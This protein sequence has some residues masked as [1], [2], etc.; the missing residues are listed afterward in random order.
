MPAEHAVMQIAGKINELHSNLSRQNWGSASRS[1]FLASL[2]KSVDALDDLY[3]LFSE[4]IAEIEKEH[5]VGKPDLQPFLGEMQKLLE[6]LHRNLQM[7]KEKKSVAKTVNV[8]EKEETPELYSDLQQKILAMLL[9]SRYSL[10]RISV[11]LR[12]QG[13]EIVTD[14]S[15]AKQVIEVLQRKEDELQDLRGKY[16][17]IRKKS[18]MGYFE[19]DTVADMEHELIEL[20]KKLFLNAD[21][22]GKTMNLHRSRLEQAES[23]YA[24]LLQKLDGM[25]QAFSLH[26]QKSG[27][28]VRALKK[29]RDYAKKIVL[30]IEN[31]TLQLR[32]TY[33]REMLNLQESKLAAKKEAEQHF[34]GEI[35]KLQKQLSE[36]HDLL[37]HFKKVAEDKLNKEQALEEK[38]KQLTM[39]LK[40][41]E[42][43][44]AVKKHYREAR[45]RKNK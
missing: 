45:K 9:K 18:Y 14:K 29:E 31:E 22:V 5:A 23:S 27:D 6:S 12:R 32:N 4:A 16:E 34:S 35:K 30:D 36:E 10:E 7:E 15:T 40:T 17:A 8:L 33:S 41:K 28:L 21:D 1:S 2:Q 20:G 42:K 43:H 3:F 26:T 24:E 44:E 13:I 39:L 25:Q 11:F 38:I 37:Q 19:E